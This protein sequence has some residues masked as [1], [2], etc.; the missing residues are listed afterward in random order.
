MCGNA[1][2]M[3]N[4]VLVPCSARL[5]LKI[6]AAQA[7]KSAVPEATADVERQ[8]SWQAILAEANEVISVLQSWK[9]DYFATA[10]P[11][12]SYIVFL[13]ASVL[14]LNCK[15]MVTTP[16]LRSSEHVDLCMLFLNQIGNYWPIGTWYSLLVQGKYDP[17]KLQLFTFF[18]ES[19]PRCVMRS[20]CSCL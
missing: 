12:Y 5:L 3:A 15:T 7:N 6:T 4:Q 10:D 18:R 13:A 14:I 16:T 8:R 1:I 9:P 20:R 11:M 17:I 2:I 19:S